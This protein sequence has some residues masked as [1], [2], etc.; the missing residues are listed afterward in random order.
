MEGAHKRNNYDLL[1]G[2]INAETLSNNK[3]LDR[4]AIIKGIYL[5]R[6]MYYPGS[7]YIDFHKDNLFILSARGILGYTEDLENE[8]KFKQIKNNID[9]FITIDQFLKSKS[10]LY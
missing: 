10:L 3:I 9:K 7:G 2:K 4:Y 1:V 8:L 6:E 5:G